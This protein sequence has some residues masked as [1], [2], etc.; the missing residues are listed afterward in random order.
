VRDTSTCQF[1][2]YRRLSIKLALT[3]SCSHAYT[4]LPLLPLNSYLEAFV[5]QASLSEQDLMPLRIEHEKQ[6]REK[7]EQERQQLL[8]MKEDLVKV[9]LIKKE[10]LKK[11][12]EQ[13]EKM[14]D[15]LKPISDALA[16]DM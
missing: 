15:G 13:L 5:D 12:D 10:E 7:L 2:G 8:K 1:A 11:M 16:K 9:N 3:F 4:H 14:I 6:E